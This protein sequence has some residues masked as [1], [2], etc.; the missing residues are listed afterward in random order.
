MRHAAASLLLAD[1]LPI[2]AGST[3]VVRALTSTTPNVYA[4][5]LPWAD[6]ATAEV[7]ERLL[8]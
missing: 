7:M 6:H 4:Y 5:I 1:G 3:M 2:T 8:G